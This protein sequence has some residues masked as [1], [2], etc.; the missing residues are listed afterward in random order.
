MK[1]AAI[2][3]RTHSGWGAVI[4]VSGDATA[5]EIVARSR[6]SVVD[7]KMQGPFQPY[8]RAASKTLPDAQ[9]YLAQCATDCEGFAVTALQQL[10]HELRAGGHRLVGCAVLTGSGRAMPPLE[11]ILAAHPLLHTAEGIFFRQVFKNAFEKLG[12]RVAEI[13]ERDLGE[14]CKAAF[15]K[16]ASGVRGKI[17]R[18]GKKLGP[19]WTTDQKLA[20]QAAWIILAAKKSLRRGQA[21]R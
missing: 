21:H 16:K 5:L 1:F 15:G 10:H 9:K 4:A 2:G 12:L 18:M 14:H 17:A 13:P 20:A 8:H 6:I 7:P 3:V 11:K 19:P